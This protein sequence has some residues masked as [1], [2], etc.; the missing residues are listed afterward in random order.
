LSSS[1]GEPHDIKYDIV[2]TESRIL[3]FS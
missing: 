2:I 3:S 1:F